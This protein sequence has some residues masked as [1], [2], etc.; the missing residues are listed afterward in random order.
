MESRKKTD[1]Y[2]VL[3]PRFI[4]FPKKKRDLKREEG[5]LIAVIRHRTTKSKK[6]Q[7]GRKE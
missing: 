5:C 2:A 3:I 1:Y 4:S 6:E 7:K